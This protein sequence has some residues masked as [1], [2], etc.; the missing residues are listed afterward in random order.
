MRTRPVRQHQNEYRAAGSLRRGDQPAAAERLV[1]GMRRQD[2]RPA[3]A[4]Q[5]IVSPGGQRAPLRVDVLRAGHGGGSSRQVNQPAASV[6]V[7]SG[8]GWRR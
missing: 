4:Q 5:R 3:R 8:A 7:S 6:R 1:V 2:H